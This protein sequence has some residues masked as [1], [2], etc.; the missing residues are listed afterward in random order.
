MPTAAVVW[1]YCQ[2]SRRGSSLRPS[3]PRAC[4][5]SS[6]V[7]CASGALCVGLGERRALPLSWLVFR[8]VFV[9]A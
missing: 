5:A 6:R 7:A 3:S 9:R 2:R 8:G 4:I 1:W